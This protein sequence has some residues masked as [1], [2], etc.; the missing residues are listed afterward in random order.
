MQLVV[1]FV[2]IAGIKI[3]MIGTGLGACGG[4]SPKHEHRRGNVSCKAHPVYL[5][6]VYFFLAC[7]MLACL[8]VDE[9]RW[10]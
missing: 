5:P 1:H 10:R 2:R 7:A 9:R 4:M 8:I 6:F 3:E